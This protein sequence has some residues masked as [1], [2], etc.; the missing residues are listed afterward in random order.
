VHQ[1]CLSYP[2]TNSLLHLQ[3]FFSILNAMPS[4]LSPEPL[5]LPQWKRPPKTRSDLEWA[6]ISVIDISTFDEAGGKERLAEKLRNAV[7]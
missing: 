1:I 6:D 5:P 3:L 7:R 2:D 4:A